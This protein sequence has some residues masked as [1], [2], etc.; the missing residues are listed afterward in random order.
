MEFAVLADHRIKLK[1]NKM[2][3][4]LE[5]AGELKTTV[6]HESDNYAN[7]DWYFWYTYQRIMKGA[8]GLG[9]KS[10]K[11]DH[12]TNYIIKNG[13]NTQKSPW[14]LIRLVVTQAQVK[15]HHLTLMWKLSRSKW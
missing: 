11:G 1:E 3:K 6:E 7:R 4:Y 15:D 10:T 2:D 5:L 8:G 12:P 9:N 13:Q 14:D